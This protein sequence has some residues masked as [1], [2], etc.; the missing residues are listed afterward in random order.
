MG[1]TAGKGSLPGLRSGVRAWLGGLRA[2]L[3]TLGFLTAILLPLVYL[4]LMAFSHPWV[5]DYANF[6][7]LVGVHVASVLVG[8]NFGAAEP[9]G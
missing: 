1:S 9:E 7:K 5:I 8:Q 4:P 2:A 6:V 3:R